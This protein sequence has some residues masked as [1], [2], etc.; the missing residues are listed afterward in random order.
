VEGGGRDVI[1]GMVTA[2]GWRDCGKLRNP[3]STVYRMSRP[4]FE[5]ACLMHKVHLFIFAFVLLIWGGTKLQAA[6]SQV[7]FPIK[8]L[9]FSIKLIPPAALWLW[10]RL[11]F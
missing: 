8:S 4:R 9:D 1:Q 5:H 2:F 10:G 7:R 11:S 6:N 3:I